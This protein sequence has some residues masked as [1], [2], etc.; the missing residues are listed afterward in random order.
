MGQKRI[1]RVWVW[2]SFCRLNPFV[3][4]VRTD[5][6]HQLAK[7][8]SPGWLKL[9]E[10]KGVFMWRLRW[11]K[12]ASFLFTD[13]LIFIPPPPPAR[14]LAHSSETGKLPTTLREPG[15]VV[16][17]TVNKFA[18]RKRRETCCDLNSRLSRIAPEENNRTPLTWT[19]R[20]SSHIV[21]CRR[22]QSSTSADLTHSVI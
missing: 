15:S 20:S 7:L 16:T 14:S 8:S 6:D 11:K 5:S 10:Q 1:N 19:S 13:S 22:L 2:W 4:S 9:T 17:D 3:R 12:S 21:A 18:T